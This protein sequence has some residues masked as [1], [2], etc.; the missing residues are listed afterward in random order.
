MLGQAGRGEPG[1]AVISAIGG[2][3]G[4]GKTALALRWAH[5]AAGRF[6]DGQLYVNLRGYDSAEPVP[7]EAALAVFLRALGVPGPDIP[8]GAEERAAAYRSLLADRTMLILLDNARCV[9]QVRPLLTASSSCVTLVTSR[10]ALA[11]LVARDGASPGDAG[12]AA[13][14]RRHR[15]ADRADR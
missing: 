13:A 6:P 3:A 1:T 8:A 12:S 14:G 4:V 2:A 5:Q 11:G 10:D 15:L 7:A 9:E